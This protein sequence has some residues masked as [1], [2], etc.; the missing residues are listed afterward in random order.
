MDNWHQPAI[1]GD[2]PTGRHGMA[3]AIVGAVAYYF[4]GEDG[5]FFSSARALKLEGHLP[6]I[7]SCLGFT[8]AINS[9]C[10]V[11]SPKFS[12]RLHLHYLVSPPPSSSPLADYRAAATSTTSGR[13]ISTQCMTSIPQTLR[14]TSRGR[15]CLSRRAA[16]HRPL[17]RKRP[18]LTQRTSDREVPNTHTQCRTQCSPALKPRSSAA[19]TSRALPKDTA[20][21]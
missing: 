10:A 1:S 7:L 14:T 19:S 6:A 5:S 15:S 11:S 16:S 12:C 13:S 21:P 3:N 18:R 4:G 17:A 20:Q 8:V 2:P 9:T